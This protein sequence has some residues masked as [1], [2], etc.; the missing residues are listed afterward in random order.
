LLDKNKI[1]L[2][3]KRIYIELNEALLSKLQTTLI[4]KLA[5]ANSV[6]FS[7]FGFLKALSMVLLQ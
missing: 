2:D 5:V 1:K 4:N 7:I 3:E 6:E